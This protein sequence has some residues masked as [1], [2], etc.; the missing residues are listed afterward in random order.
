MLV[1]EDDAP[2]ADQL[3]WAFKD[4]YEVHTASEREVA[5]R[6]LETVSPDLIL[7]DLCLPPDNAPEEGFRLL[8]AARSRA[9]N[10]VVVVMSGREEREAALRAVDEGAYDFFTKPVDLSALRVVVG[11]ALER[12][13]LERENRRLRETLRERF[14]VDGIV[15]TSPSMQRVFDAIRRV[16]DSSV[17]VSILGE[18]GTG[19]EL[20]ARAI[21]FSGCRS[22]GPFVA[23]H[24]A[25]LPEN[26][27]EAELFGHEKGAFTGAVSSRIGRFEAAHGGTLFLDEI[28]CLNVSTQMKLLRVLEQRAVER[29]GSNR[30]HPVDIR[31]VVAS[32]EDLQAKVRSGD[33]REDLFFRV[34]VFPIQL[35]P[36]RERR[37]DI[38]LLAEHFLKRICEAGK[39]PPKRFAPEVRVAL[40]SRDWPG[41]VRELFNTV[42]TIA[43][44]SDGDTI[45]VE[46]I[47]PEG[48][49]GWE[50]PALL[51][52]RNV[53]FKSA[54]DDCERRLLVEAIEGA[55]GVKVKAARELGLNQSQM[56][57]LSQK[58]H[59]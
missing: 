55:G 56:K 45:G 46:A 35:P 20:V 17:T 38:P 53:G 22:E 19:K 32:N 49:A 50:E 54:V 41:N 13:A 30:L 26:L 39:L 11:R 23:V 24:C 48:R 33:F 28:S 4:L 7:M 59:L 8:R 37:G 25:A 12:Q 29:L 34:H 36:L 1:V 43:L 18:S 16:A 51:R 15:G 2:L 5:L 47:A 14:Q 21:H 40:A 27:L 6:A 52:A 3:R 10:T 44:L 58:H 9:S 57:Y 42:E 31:L